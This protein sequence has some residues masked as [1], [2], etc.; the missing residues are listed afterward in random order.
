M[1][2]RRD[3]KKE[4]KYNYKHSVE[5]YLGFIKPF[6]PKLISYTSLKTMT[7]R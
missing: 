3:E 1:M 4:K 5:K 7:T 2:K 6:T